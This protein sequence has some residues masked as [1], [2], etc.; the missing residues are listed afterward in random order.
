ML[1]VG[2]IA[3][4]SSPYCHRTGYHMDIKLKRNSK[5]QYMLMSHYKIVMIV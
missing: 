2:I 3:S 4:S 1:N 5:P